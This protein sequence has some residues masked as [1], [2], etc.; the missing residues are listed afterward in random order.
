MSFD[1]TTA[2]TLLDEDKPTSTSKAH[3]LYL[4]INLEVPAGKGEKVAPMT[5]VFAPDPSQL[6]TAE[7]DVILWLHGNKT[8][9]SQ[10]RGKTQEMPGITIQDYLKVDE[11]KLREFILS[12]K[13]TQFLLVAPTLANGTTNGGLL[14]IWG[15]AEAYFN[16]V[17]N[18]VNA[19]MGKSLGEK[20][21]NIIL[22]AHSG[23]GKILGNMTAFGG[24]FA[25]RVE[26]IWCFD[27][28]Y[29]DNIS[30][31][32]DKNHA[33][34]RL[35]VYSSGEGY[36][37]K[38]MPNPKFDPQKPVSKDNPKVVEMMIPNPKF[39]SAKP[40][41]D[42]NP[43]FQKAGTGD[44][45]LDILGKANKKAASST[46]IEVL[47]EAYS[48]TLI[49]EQSTPHFLETYG[50]PDGRKHYESIAKYLPQLVDSSK[51][52]QPSP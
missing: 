47:I 39:N 52:L 51:N 6:K 36:G 21:K 44:T 29:W 38:W 32:A 33:A 15:W 26:E 23:G 24:I 9:W 46:T 31:W 8:V 1:P 45:A 40:E 13:K 12:Q 37:S 50:R 18:G 25:Q 4:E 20:P 35:F 19:Y 11:C 30:D 7:W 41:S 43:K 17:R 3:T 5:A 16:A 49:R 42:D 14:S 34:R 2:P 10:K 28:T 27:C 22:A 48:G